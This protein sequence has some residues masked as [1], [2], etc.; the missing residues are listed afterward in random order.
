MEILVMQQLELDAMRVDWE[1]FGIRPRLQL[2]SSCSRFP[3]AQK[4][5]ASIDNHCLYYDFF[6]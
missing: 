4:C 5:D 1:I 6:A 2:E 3:L